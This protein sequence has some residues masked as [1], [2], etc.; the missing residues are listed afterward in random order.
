MDVRARR[1]KAEKEARKQGMECLGHTSD[2]DTPDWIQVPDRFRLSGSEGEYTTFDGN[3][4]VY[5]LISDGGGGAIVY[6][7]LESDYYKTTSREGTCPN[8]QAY[9]RRYEEDD[10]LTCHRCGW[11]YKPLTAR[12]LNLL[13]L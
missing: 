2:E 3:N 13:R 8:C 10:Y 7:Q 6:R 5:K 9:V 1:R 4:Y 12:I 11:Q